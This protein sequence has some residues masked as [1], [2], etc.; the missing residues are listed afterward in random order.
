MP[1]ETATATPDTDT[2]TTTTIEY[3][4]MSDEELEKPY[5]VIIQNDDVTPMD[6]VVQVLLVIFELDMVRAEVV[7]LEAHHTG[8]ALVTMLPLREAQ[9][10]VYIAH[11]A[12]RAAGYPLSFYLEPDS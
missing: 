6:F 8:H 1:P 10:R 2:T 3:V 4:V 5:K 9:E 12:A 7:M 11:S